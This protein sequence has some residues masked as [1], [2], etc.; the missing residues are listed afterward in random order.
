MTATI[1]IKNT[2]TGI[3]FTARIVKEGDRYGRDMCLTHEEG[4][5]PLIEF[6]DSRYPFDRA[7]EG[8]V[9]GQFVSRYYVST[10]RNSLARNG[11]VTGLCLD[12]GVRDWTL[13]RPAMMVVHGY[14]EANT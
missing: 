1:K 14:I 11:D 10:L 5:E 12:G 9:L 2:D 8:E 3:T 13:N 4:K 7:P 6:Y